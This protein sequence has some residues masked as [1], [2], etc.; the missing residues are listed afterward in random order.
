MPM[1]K[2]FLVKTYA[3]AVIT[4]GVECYALNYGE[5]KGLASTV[6]TTLKRAIGLKPRIHNDELLYALKMEPICRHIIRK[7]LKFFIEML[8]NN[9]MRYMIEFIGSQINTEIGNGKS[10]ERLLLKKSIVA[11]MVAMNEQNMYQTD[12]LAEKIKKTYATIQAENFLNNKS[13]KVIEIR[14]LLTNPSPKNIV[15]IN[16]LL[17]PEELRKHNKEKEEDL[18]LSI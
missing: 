5:L 12:E 16:E 1:V 3:L 14:F 2:A 15:A 13:D 9:R 4:Y 11:E 18:N 7:K 10:I 8:N 17:C 6:S